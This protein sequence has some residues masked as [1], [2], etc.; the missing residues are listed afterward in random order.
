M[1]LQLKLKNLKPRQVSSLV[2]GTT[3]H[4]TGLFITSLSLF[5]LLNSVQTLVNINKYINTNFNVD[6]SLCASVGSY[7][8]KIEMLEINK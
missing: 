5:L 8:V 2:A 4:H 1:T 6:I 3:T 7:Y